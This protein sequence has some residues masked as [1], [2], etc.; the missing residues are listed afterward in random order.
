MSEGAAE[1][2]HHLGAS[3]NHAG[4]ADDHKFN[5]LVLGEIQTDADTA[6]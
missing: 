6:Y 3:N 1:F 5:P 2:L 4:R